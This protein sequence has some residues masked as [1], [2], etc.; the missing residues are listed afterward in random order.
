MVSTLVLRILHCIRQRGGPAHDTP[1]CVYLR[2]T[3]VGP[4]LIQSSP[5]FEIPSGA[6]QLLKQR[7]ACL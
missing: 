1:E 4:M 7:G 6:G 5:R 2:Q 3:T